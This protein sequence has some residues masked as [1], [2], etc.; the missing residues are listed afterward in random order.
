MKVVLSE[1]DIKNILD[2]YIA[3]K[4]DL[5]PGTKGILVPHCDDH[6]DFTDVEF[7]VEIK[8]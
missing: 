5:P 8:G 3:C 2:E 1:E 4:F 6:G 7:Q